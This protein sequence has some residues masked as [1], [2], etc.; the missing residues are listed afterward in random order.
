[1]SKTQSERITAEQQQYNATTGFTNS[2]DNDGYLFTLTQPLRDLGV[3]LD[4]ESKSIVFNDP[5]D[6]RLSGVVADSDEVGEGRG[7]KNV[8]KIRQGDSLLVFIRNDELEEIGVEFDPDDGILPV[9]NVYAGDGVITFETI[10]FEE[11]DLGMQTLEKGEAEIDRKLMMLPEKM[12]QDYIAVVE[13]GKSPEEWAEERDL[14]A[15]E[16]SPNLP[17]NYIKQRVETAKSKLDD[18]EGEGRP[19]FKRGGRKKE[20]LQVGRRPIA[21]HKDSYRVYIT[22]AVKRAVPESEWS[23]V[24]G[25]EY[26]PDSIKDFGKLFG[27]IVMEDEGGNF[28]GRSNPRVNSITRASPNDGYEGSSF[29]VYVP[30]DK[31]E[32]LGYDLA[33]IERRYANNDPLQIKIHA[34]SRMVGFGHDDGP[35][36]RT[37]EVPQPSVVDRY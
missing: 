29:Y 36:T 20:I 23:E 26:I 11:V 28:D 10:Q 27:G 13:E 37:I 22:D 31:L 24:T 32:A 7:G 9:V 6:G 4:G 5:S 2:A 3:E 19:R 21:V 34:G 16:T 1:M 33:E 35:D 25:I 30:K 18:V 8:R 15:T 12:R 14:A 17:E